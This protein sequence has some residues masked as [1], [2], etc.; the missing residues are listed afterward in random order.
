MSGHVASQTPYRMRAVSTASGSLEDRAAI[1]L[2]TPAAVGWTAFLCGLPAGFVLAAINYRRMGE[3]DKAGMRLA[4]A[5]GLLAAILFSTFALGSLGG[6]L[7]LAMYVGG[8]IFLVK[9]AQSSA[10]DY[11]A[12]HPAYDAHGFQGFL[13]G[14]GVAVVCS[15]T[16]FGLSAM[17]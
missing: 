16:F 9:D 7:N 13:I 6:L 8:I 12:A 1:D 17:F 15:V 3:G 11:R 14:L 5:A 10:A 4:G 2:F